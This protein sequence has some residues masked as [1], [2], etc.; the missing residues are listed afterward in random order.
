[1]RQNDAQHTV[2]GVRFDMKDH[3][4]HHS[5]CSNMDATQVKDTIL[6]GPA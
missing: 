3:L 2:Y 6:N 4:D 5:N 1:M